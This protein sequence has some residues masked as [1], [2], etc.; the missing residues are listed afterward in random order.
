MKEGDWDLC[1]ELARFLAAM[2]ETGEVLQEVMKM[3]NAGVKGQAEHNTVV[4]RLAIPSSRIPNGGSQSQSGSGED[5]GTESDLRST[6]DAASINST[7]SPL[8]GLGRL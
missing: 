7:I 8:D 1:K 2:D 3:A 4:S 5:D 6:S